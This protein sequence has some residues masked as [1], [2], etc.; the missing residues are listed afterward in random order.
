MNIAHIANLTYNVC[1]FY[2]ASHTK[3]ECFMNQNLTL[4][5]HQ[6]NSKVSTSEDYIL[7]KSNKKI[8]KKMSKPSFSSL[9]IKVFRAVFQRKAIMQKV[10]DSWKELFFF[11]LSRTGVWTLDLMLA[12]WV[13]YYLSH[14]PS[15]FC[16]DYFLNS[17]SKDCD[18]GQQSFYA[19]LLWDWD[20]SYVP[21][22]PAG[23]LKLDLTFFFF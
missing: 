16:K 23:L 13:L 20:N 15:S 11:F 10:I 2:T 18:L 8:G 9:E 12:R 17:L 5:S 4:S 21:L 22:G 14:T 1:I 6:Q 7:W 19:C 3:L